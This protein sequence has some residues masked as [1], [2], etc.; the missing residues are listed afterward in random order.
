MLEHWGVCQIGIQELSICI[1][2][3]FAKVFQFKIRSKFERDVL[4]NRGI[5]SEFLNFPR[6][7]DVVGILG[8]EKYI[9][10]LLATFWLLVFYFF[11]S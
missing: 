2:S 7:K 11:K 10:I 3:S 1:F 8:K 9:C 5:F 6:K 4:K